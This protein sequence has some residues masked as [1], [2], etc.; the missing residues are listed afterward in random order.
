MGA[1]LF[2]SYVGSII[3]ACTLGLSEG[4]GAIGLALP[5][6]IA[7]FGILCSIFG[8]ICVRTQEG[9]S[10]VRPREIGDDGRGGCA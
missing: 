6:L 10:Q 2:E 4:Y 7:S 8:T 9:A 3:A 1:D 5:L